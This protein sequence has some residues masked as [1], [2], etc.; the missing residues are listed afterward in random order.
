MSTPVISL[1]SVGIII[2]I[3]AVIFWP[4][5]GLLPR[6]RR[7]QQNTRRVLIEDALKHLYDLEYKDFTCTLQ[8]IS[9]FL[10]IS[11]EKSIQVMARLE[12]LGLARAHSD[13]FELTP[14][15]RSYA[16]RMIRVHR[17][18]E[19]YLADETGMA[20]TD[21]HRKAEK[22]EH[23][24]SE[25]EVE[26]L[27]ASVGHPSYDPH[28]DP[29]PTRTGKLPPKKGQPLTDLKEG[30][31]AEILHLEDE[32]D[33]IYAQL[34][35]ERLHPGM[36]IRILEKSTQRLSFI[37]KGEEVVLAPIV[38]A[39]ITV[40]P[41]TPQKEFEEPFESLASLKI[42]ERAEV[43]GLSKACRGQ[44]RRRIMDLGVIPGTVVSAEMK[45]ASGDPTA[46]KI[47]GALIALR[48]TQA[49]L[50]QIKPKEAA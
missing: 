23:N 41:I 47:R 12:S 15:G 25:R 48:K 2:V 43:T 42:G 29:I 35:A 18:W 34:V 6:W 17:L 1:L 11:N 22:L 31:L 19:R 27:D 40:E 44:Q 4:K 10:A 50:I 32:P 9:G 33:S 20:E 24:M 26:V 49:E 30:E 3:S 7:S 21:W 36:Q 46:Y 45:S 39:N 13:G 28:G 16:L 5:I 14:E 8:S 37:A 38:A